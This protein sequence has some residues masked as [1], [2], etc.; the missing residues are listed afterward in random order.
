MLFAHLDRCSHA[1]M[2]GDKMRWK[3]CACLLTAVFGLGNA[4]AGDR[5]VGAKD[6]AWLTL[7]AV[8]VTLHCSGLACAP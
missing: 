3:H 1:K 2:T 7:A 6:G 8:Y 4:P 5:E